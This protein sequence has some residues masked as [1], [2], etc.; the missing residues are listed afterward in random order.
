[1]NKNEPED[2][3]HELQYDPHEPGPLKTVE[4][5]VV[6]RR[7][8]FTAHAA[9]CACF[10][11]RKCLLTNPIT[12]PVQYIS[13]VPLYTNQCIKNAACVCPCLCGDPGLELNFQ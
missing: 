2:N 13:T 4:V 8:L 3:H 9:S 7:K 10:V 11:Y 6:L 5:A 1:M 12:C